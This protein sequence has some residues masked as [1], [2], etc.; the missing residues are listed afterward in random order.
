MKNNNDCQ[1]NE[2][3]DLEKKLQASFVQIKVSDSGLKK[4]INSLPVTNISP[5]RYNSREGQSAGYFN[6]F[7]LNR[8]KLAIPAVL[9]IILLIG[10]AMYLSRGSSTG[11]QL[12]QK[13][14][15]SQTNAITPSP[16][17]SLVDLETMLQSELNDELSLMT[18]GDSGE[19]SRLSG[20]AEIFNEIN[21]TYDKIEI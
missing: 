13:E 10:G 15:A 16:I 12:A 17:N 6:G 8:F 20:E 1:F 21:K 11:P 14:A 5:Q 3:F 19:T 9:A 4:I 18:L 2:S 7:V